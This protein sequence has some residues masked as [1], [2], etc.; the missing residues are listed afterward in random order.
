MPIFGFN[1][2]YIGSMTYCNPFCCGSVFPYNR[3][4]LGLSLM[5]AAFT[6]KTKYPE[7]IYN[8][9]IYIPDISIGDLNS[10][11]K[12]KQTD[13]KSPVKQTDSKFD[14]NEYLKLQS[15]P[16]AP[17]KPAKPSKVKKNPRKTTPSGT[18]IVLNKTEIVQLACRI[19]RKYKVDERLVLAIIDAESSF[20]SNA[21]SNK[22][23]QGLMQLMP[24]TAKELGVTNRL[25]PE[26]N[27]DGGVRYLKKLLDMY[28]GDIKF[29]LAAYNA[30]LGN[31]RKYNGIPPFKETQNYV[32]KIY[33]NYKN[34]TVA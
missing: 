23:A 7:Q 29:A 10:R 22:G 5:S 26:Q 2:F 28:K 11:L 14:S 32:N 33:N 3:M 8:E 18:K 17:V 19:A 30:G 24:A 25:D 21:G 13:T 4:F 34:Y 16:K 31:V 20:N 27:I 1:S 6:P 12:L 9:E 15:V